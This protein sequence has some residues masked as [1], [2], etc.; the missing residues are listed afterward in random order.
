MERHDL[1]TRVS[2]W[3][4]GS[5]PQEDIVIASRIRL[6]RNLKGNSFPHILGEEDQKRI[7]AKVAKAVK[8]PEVTKVFGTME[9]LLLEELSLLEKQILVEKHLISPAFAESEGIGAVVLNEDETVSIMVN[10]EDH[11]RL[12]LL[13]PALQLEETLEMANSLDD[14]LE[15]VLDFA[16]NEEQGYLTACPTNLGT[17]LRA[18][19]MLHLP[20]LVITKQAKKIFSSLSQIGLAVRGFY[21][22]G[23]EAQGNLFQVS[24]QITLGLVE[25]EIISNLSLVVQQIIDQE[26]TARERLKEEFKHKIEDKVRRAY[27]LMS[28]ARIMSSEEAIELLSD[29]RL[30]IDLEM[31]TGVDGRILNEMMA[32]IQ[33]GLL[34]GRGKKMMA[35]SE[36]DLRRAEAIQ[37]KL[38]S[39]RR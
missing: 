36:R 8:L 4:E 2:K 35:S 9:V 6:A 27:G 37:E 12:Q 20:A 10:E 26:R 28:Y 5:G 22:E 29:L 39:Q 1:A 13:M 34:Q 32:F 38:Q 25:E 33:P 21:G 7:V 23:S 31:I 16:F 30:G 19:V 15:Q 18:S 17:G 11:L 3:M 24:N 14:A